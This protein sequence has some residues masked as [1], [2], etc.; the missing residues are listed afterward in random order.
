MKISK[1]NKV[2]SWNYLDIQVHV[3]IILHVSTWYDDPYKLMY[4]NGWSPIV[5]VLWGE[6]WGW[7]L[8]FQTPI[9]LHLVSPHLLTLLALA[10]LW[11]LSQALPISVSVSCL[12]FRFK[13]SGTIPAHLPAAILL[14]KMIKGSDSREL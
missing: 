10:P 12:C 14:S 5:G 6:F 13:S 9:P 8:R 1:D 7:V 4:L 11:R 2:K 3:H